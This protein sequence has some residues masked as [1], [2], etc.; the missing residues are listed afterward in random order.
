MLNV[1]TMNNKNISWVA[2]QFFLHG[3]AGKLENLSQSFL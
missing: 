1:T 2:V 3:P